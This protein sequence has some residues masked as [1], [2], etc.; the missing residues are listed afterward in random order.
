MKKLYCWR[1]F[2]SAALIA[3]AF[4]IF[5]SIACWAQ[6]SN[7]SSPKDAYLA[8]NR[9][10]DARYKTDVLV[11]VAHPD[12]E[13]MAAAWCGQRAVTAAPTTPALSRRPPWATFVRWRGSA[14][15]LVWA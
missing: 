15:R 14:Q 9:Q 4:V 3:G 11:V 7:A 1:K 8:N 5:N 2:G 13:V 12:D 10:P 6:E